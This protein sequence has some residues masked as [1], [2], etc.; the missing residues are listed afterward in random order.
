M[1]FKQNIKNFFSRLGSYTI[2]ICRDFIGM[3]EFI[4]ELVFAVVMAVKNPRKIRW[5]ETAYYMAVC[6]SD[7]LPIV[8]LL[9]FLMGLIIAF[10]SAVQLQKY[11][12]DTLV[13]VI[14]GC[15]ITRELSPLMV[16]VI[17]TGRAG[18][19]FA[20]EIGTMKTNEEIDAM[21]TMGFVPSRFLLMPKLIAMILVT[22]VL[23]VFGN[24]FGILG[25]MAV[26]IYKLDIPLLTYYQSTISSVTPMYF[27]EGLI[28]GFVF[29]VLI[30]AAGCMRGMQSSRD[31]QGVGRSATSAVV[32]SI[33][34]IVI[35]DAMLTVVFTN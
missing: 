27:S 17:A 33:F 9:C 25:G 4:G 8:A 2:E 5:K 3:L 18:S 24:I 28:K 20:A 11:G 16:A 15:S 26:G 23:V 12:A 14:V 34:L 7:A 35:A 32:T 13:P 29:A 10:Q 21:I 22:P 19:A 31:A 30:A 1:S 6:G